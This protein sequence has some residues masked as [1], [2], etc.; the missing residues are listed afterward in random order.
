[1]VM[2]GGFYVIAPVPPEI[3]E[4]S[5]LVM[6]RKRSKVENDR[7]K[8]RCQPRGC[9]PA[10]QDRGG[11]M[12]IAARAERTQAYVGPA[13]ARWVIARH[14]YPADAVAERNKRALCGNTAANHGV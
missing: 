13:A 12:A 6:V 1:M 7:C 2:D 5:V 8:D 4:G 14:L 3:G 11:G 9:F 10:D